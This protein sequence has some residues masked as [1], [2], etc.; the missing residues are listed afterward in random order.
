MMMLVSLQT[1]EMFYV[2][3]KKVLEGERMIFTH[4]V[5]RIAFCYTKFLR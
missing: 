5:K 4:M 1:G 2:E 3:L